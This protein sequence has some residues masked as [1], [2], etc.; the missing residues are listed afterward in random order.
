[1][2]DEFDNDGTAGD[3][4]AAVVADAV[5]DAAADQPSAE[6]SAAATSATDQS[7][8]E[9]PAGELVHFN[10]WRDFNDAPLVI[11]PFGVEPDRAQNAIFLDVVFSWCEGLLPVRGFV[12]KGQGRN[13]KPH[14]IWIEADGGAVDKLVTFA[15]WA[16]REGAAVYV[17]DFRREVTQ[18]F[19]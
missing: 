8:A 1:M 11:D 4:T 13:G 17:V 14:N 10:P 12:D 6:T 3:D 19:H 9:K 5:A 15:N 18:P 16:W 7:A 2:S